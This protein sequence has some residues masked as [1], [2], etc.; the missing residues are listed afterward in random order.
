MAKLLSYCST[1][2]HNLIVN[3]KISRYKHKTDVSVLL[4]CY[5]L[6]IFSRTD[7]NGKEIAVCLLSRC[8][9]IE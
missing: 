2:S 8:L 3:R 5:I 9:I 7:L 1:G 4:Y 6:L